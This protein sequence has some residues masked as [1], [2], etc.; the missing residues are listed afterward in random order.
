MHMYE[1]DYHEN[2]PKNLSQLYPAYVSELSRFIC[3]SRGGITEESIRK[4][5]NICYQ[6]IS[7]MKEEYDAKCILAFDRQGNHFGQ[8]VLNNN[9][10]RNVLFLYRG[11]EWIPEE[12]WESTWQKH[13]SCLKASKERIKAK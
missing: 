5:Y 4:D 6:Y 7:G 11:C 10:G 8:D 13:L 1:Q 3:A 12:N 9:A 2:F